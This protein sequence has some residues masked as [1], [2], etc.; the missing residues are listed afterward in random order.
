M[1]DAPP[2]PAGPTTRVEVA[3]HVL[4]ALA[5]LFLFLFHL[6]P[7]LVAGLLVHAILQKTARVLRGPRV[8]HGVAKWLALLIVGLLASGAVTLLVLIMIS[9][10]RGHSGDLPALF[11]KMA[12]ALEQTGTRLRSMGLGTR[13]MES[14]STAE[15]VKAAVTDWFREHSDEL[16]KTGGEVGRLFVHC[17]MGMLVALFVFF[18][19][20]DGSP[21]PLAAALAERIRRFANAFEMVI[22]AQLE[23]SALNTFLT[24]IYVL[25]IVPLVGAKLPLAGTL[26]AV[27]FVTGLIPVVGN[28]ISNTVI[29]VISL[30][31][32]P[33]IAALSL[34]FLVIVHK[35]EYFVNAKIV[36]SRIHAAAWEILLSIVVMEVAFGVPGVVLAPVI[37]AYAKKELGDKGL[38]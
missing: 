34:A 37:Y 6:V 9:V 19:P 5:L 10:L 23:I 36:G 32:S 20:H 26:V 12:E 3:A 1:T 11:Q 35:L 7:A 38:V 17:I 15:D 31:V 28:L 22:T 21:R 27:T 16:K 4:I 14:L 2:A 25:G 24:S 8:S 29:V 18:R 30:G 13:W 33:W